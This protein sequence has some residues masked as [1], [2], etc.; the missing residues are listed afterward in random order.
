M[1]STAG[2]T[3]II[4]TYNEADTIKVLLRQL[5][6]LQNDNK[7]EIIIV[8]AESSDDNLQTEI[9]SL[10]VTLI[11]SQ[12]TSRAKQMNEG[13]K[14]A[15]HDILYFLHADAIPPSSFQ[16]D[17]CN[18]IARKNQFGYFSYRFDSSNVLLKIN[19]YFSK[20]KSF[21]TGGGDQSFYIQKSVFIAV[22]RFDSNLEVCEDFDIYHRLRKAKKKYE[23]I[24]SDVKISA[25]KYQK[26]N[27]IWI[28]LVNFYILMR[29]KLG[30]NPDNLKTQYAKLLK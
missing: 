27:Y 6:S 29:F 11:S 7:V 16:A 24:N 26:S 30:H 1:K 15:S 20:Y 10:P 25:R 12:Y 2:I 14:H 18:S 22:G 28:N 9:S 23:I 19:S 5:L 13:A 17:I 21:Y 4:P 3:V 8:D